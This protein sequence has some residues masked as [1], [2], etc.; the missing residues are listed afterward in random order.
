MTEPGERRRRT[1]S[2][3]TR[4]R[5]VRGARDAA[6]HAAD[7]LSELIRHHLEGVSAVC[8]SEDG[9][10]IVHVDVLEVA[11]IP[12]TTSLLATY[13]VELDPAGDLVQYRRIARYRRGA[14]D[15]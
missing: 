7:A 5:G 11:R 4:E 1:T 6:R 10:W 8:R 2:T 14:Q 12:D 15:Q 13:E 9:G 3:A